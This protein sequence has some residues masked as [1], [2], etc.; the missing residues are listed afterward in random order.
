MTKFL[1]LLEFFDQ[2]HKLYN[3]FLQDFFAT[4][5]D[6]PFHSDEI[7]DVHDAIISTINNRLNEAATRYNGLLL[8]NAYLTKCSPKMLSKY[9]ML[10]IGKATKELEDIDNNPQHL[11]ITCKVIGNVIT[12]CKSISELQ[13]QISMENVKQLI[14]VLDNL[15]SV[16]NCGATYYLLATLLYHY[17][18]ACERLQT[19][20]R[21]MIFIQI[22]ASKSNLVNAGAKCFALLT[23]TTER[24]FKPPQTKLYYTCWTY[25]QAL[26]CN[27]LHDIMDSFFSDLLETESV[28]IWDKLKLSSISEENIFEYYSKQQQRF[29]N[30]CVYL[31][32]MLQFKKELIPYGST[33][34]QLF[35][36]TLKWTANELKDQETIS[37][38]KPL[39]NLRLSVYKCLSL[40]LISNNSLSGIETIID[41]CL[42]FVLKDIISERDRVLLTVKSTSKNLS[43]KA[44]K[45]IRD[46]QYEKNS[47]LNN[48]IAIKK[49]PC[50]DAD[51]CMEAL[52][53]LQNIL[54]CSYLKS[55]LYMNIQNVVIPLLYEY[56]LGSPVQTFYKENTQCRLQLLRILKDLQL[57]SHASL[58]PPTQYAIEI[59][60]MA[61]D[62]V[63]L[64]IVQEAQCALSELEKIIHPSAPTLCLPKTKELIEEDELR[65]NELNEQESMS[66]EEILP[67]SKKR[68]KIIDIVTF[69]S[70]EKN[71]ID[72]GTNIIDK[73]TNKSISID[74]SKSEDYLLQES[75][76]IVNRV[77]LIEVKDIEKNTEP[78]LQNSVK[79]DQISSKE[80]D[81]IIDRQSEQTEVKLIKTD[82]E[83]DLR[84]D[85]PRQ[86]DNLKTLEGMEDI[87]MDDE[88]QMLLCFQDQL[89]DE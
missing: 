58:T 76:S 33:I 56:Y 64:H 49:N 25:N 36:Q 27:S 13:K 8:L 52:I 17:P 11:S 39:K 77:P 12:Q 22:D 3:S 21:K 40:W 66:N 24:S 42:P 63:N 50:L 82:A 28:D 41:E 86:E 74:S 81:K 46:G 54:F 20:I 68:P 34:L 29:S 55:T 53:T 67:P 60:E 59:F 7:K 26:I 72:S 5:Y 10:W 2:D 37:S 1:D 35:H 38:S 18:E 85:N 23:R 32:A 84:E 9:G 87:L 6:L 57:N 14:N 79:E 73:V 4:G 51:L 70:D 62:D 30:L 69:I 43:K 44:L 83:K 31:S 61:L 65:S 71:H 89:K 47:A 75:K 19:L 45:R 78:E 88:K 48:T 16:I 80:S 15:E